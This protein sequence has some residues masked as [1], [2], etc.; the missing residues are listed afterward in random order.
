M[1]ILA[2]NSS[3]QLDVSSR[4]ELAFPSNDLALINFDVKNSLMERF[5]VFLAAVWLVFWHGACGCGVEFES[6]SI[7]FKRCQLVSFAY[8]GS[9]ILQS[10]R[11]SGIGVQY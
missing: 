6:D 7:E 11:A 3:N 4:G 5:L 9:L 1:V 8:V 10:M 2:L